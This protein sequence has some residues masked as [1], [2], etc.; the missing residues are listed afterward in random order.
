MQAHIHMP[1]CV[2]VTHAVGIDTWVIRVTRV[3]KS[4]MLQ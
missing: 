1:L 3:D 2:T 4:K